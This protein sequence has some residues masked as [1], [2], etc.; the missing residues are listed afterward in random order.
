MILKTIRKQGVLTS[1]E[2]RI[3]ELV[4]QGFASVAIGRALGLTDRRVEWHLNRIYYWLDL[5]SYPKTERNR[6]SSAAFWYLYY[7]PEIAPKE[8]PRFDKST[9]C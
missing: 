9:D 1:T 2:D 3:L 8:E 4:V 5:N 6:R 7:N